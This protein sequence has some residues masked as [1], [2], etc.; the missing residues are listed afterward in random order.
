MYGCNKKQILG[1]C[2]LPS[3]ISTPNRAIYG[4]QNCS[5]RHN[6]FLQFKMHFQYVKC[7]A[8]A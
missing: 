1:S 6:Q 2:S 3:P 4:L 8:N 7:K 5:N